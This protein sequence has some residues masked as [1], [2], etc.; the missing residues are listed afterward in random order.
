MDLRI[1]HELAELV[2]DK[3]D[4]RASPA[5]EEVSQGDEVMWGKHNPCD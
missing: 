3:R 5:G 2:H 4:V 1:R